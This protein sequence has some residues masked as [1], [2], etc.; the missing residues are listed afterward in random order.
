MNVPQSDLD[1][2]ARDLSVANGRLI[3]AIMAANRGRADEAGALAENARASVWQTVKKLERLGATSP[4]PTNPD[5]QPVPLSLLDSAANHRFY[6]AL[7]AAYEA[8][9]EVDKERG[10]YPD[11]FAAILESFC[12]DKRDEIFG[13]AGAGRE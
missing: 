11:G 5:A 10:V 3:R 2:I 8:G 13:V 9:V 12:A 7:I 4:L 1:A 6:D